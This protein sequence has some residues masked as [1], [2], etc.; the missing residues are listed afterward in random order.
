MTKSFCEILYLAYSYIIS[1]LIVPSSRLLRQP[2]DIRGKKG[3][4]FG[5]NLTT[6]YHCRLESYCERGEQSLI[7]GDNIQINDFVHISALEEV[8]IGNNVLIASKVF[9]TDL[10]H[11]SYIGD[12]NDSVPSSVVK[13]RPLSSKKVI[14]EDNVWLGE[15]VSVLPGVTI[16]ENSIIGANSVVTKS[17]PPNSIAVGCPARVIKQYNFEA[18]RWEKI[19]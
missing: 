3:I 1:K 4:D 10:E 19:R 12:E 17:I 6:G 9:I 7:F 5:K 11:G 8:R 18:K 2:I 13:D 14:I 15:H 16:G